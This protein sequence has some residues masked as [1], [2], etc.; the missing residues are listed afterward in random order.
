[1]FDL[2]LKEFDLSIMEANDIFESASDILALEVT[3]LELLEE[4][5]YFEES[6]DDNDN[7]IYEASVEKFLEGIQN[8][9]KKIKEAIVKFAKDVRNKVNLEL[10]KRDVN[11]KIKY[12]KKMMATNRQ[13]LAIYNGKKFPFFDY[14]KYMKAYKKYTNHLV[15]ELNYAYK[16][17]YKTREEFESTVSECNKRLIKTAKDLNLYEAEVYV[18]DV[19][20]HTIVDNSEKAANDIEKI[21]KLYNDEASRI[22]ETAESATK[23]EEDITKISMLKNIVNRSLSD[24]TRMTNMVIRKIIGGINHLLSVFSGLFKKE[25]K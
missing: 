1:M 14:V 20:V 2:F 22:V 10:T 6:A 11:K 9:F 3:E 16:K 7:A 19:N 13:Q 8:F 21:V 18:I 12:I 5:G 4:Q 24:L 17:D 15:K 25:N 23:Q